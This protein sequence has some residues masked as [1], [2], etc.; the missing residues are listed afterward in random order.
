MGEWRLGKGMW[1]RLRAAGADRK[2]GR[3]EVR[4]AEATRCEGRSRKR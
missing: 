4:K 3:N 1:G 2:C